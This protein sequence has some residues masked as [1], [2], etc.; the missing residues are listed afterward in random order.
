MLLLFCFLFGLALLVSAIGFYRFIYF[1]SVGY[2]FAITGMAI[3]LTVYF[4]EQITL[5]FLLH[6]I[7]LML[8]GLR[9]G[10][11]LLL[12]EYKQTYRKEMD[13]AKRD[14][15]SIRGFSKIGIWITVSLL[16]V[17]MIS[18]LAFQGSMKN[19]NMFFPY[20][21]VVIMIAGIL[22]ESIA[23]RQK[24]AFKEQ[25]PSSFCNVGLFRWSRCPNYFGEITFWTGN[26]ITGFA[27]YRGVLP[28]I[29]AAAGFC[30]IVFVMLVSTV[31]LELKQEAR[32][33]AEEVF[34][35]YARKVPLLFPFLPLYSLK[36]LSKITSLRI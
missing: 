20:L 27:V 10:I 15:S 9:L 8:Y 6:S 29:V 19:Q 14:T 18:P 28:W 35:A 5:S 2:G 31:R 16:Y 21:G 4:R 11:F 24:S 33:G 13:T 26:F 12:R 25:F 17:L 22:L 30:G 3:F 7:L 32:Y 34:Q 23:D 1:I 36:K